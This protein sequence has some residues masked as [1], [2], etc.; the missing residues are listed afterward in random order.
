MARLRSSTIESDNPVIA[1]NRLRY[2]KMLS[3]VSLHRVVFDLVEQDSLP[4]D[5]SA[6]AMLEL[7]AD[8]MVGCVG[9]LGRTI[10]ADSK[11]MDENII[12]QAWS[13][14]VECF[15]RGISAFEMLSSK[16]STGDTSA[17]YLK[18]GNSVITELADALDRKRGGMKAPR[19]YAENAAKVRRSE[20]LKS[21]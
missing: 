13:S 17:N 19:A 7:A 3:M 8:M 2:F 16:L 21:R 1:P 18:R 6:P 14:L 11:T 10:I 15:I 12:R 9:P 4:L 20:A 5:G